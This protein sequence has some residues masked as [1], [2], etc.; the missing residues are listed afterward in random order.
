[1][2][3]GY[4][5]R[6]F[7]RPF[8]VPLP[9][10]ETLHGTQGDAV[11]HWIARAA[12]MRELCAHPRVT[13]AFARW[14]AESGIYTAARKFAD[15]R[16]DYARA[17]G[18]AGRTEMLRPDFADVVLLARV[19]KPDNIE[20]MQALLDVAEEAYEKAD[21]ATQIDPTALVR[22]L[23]R[24]GWPWVARDLAGA[25]RRGNLSYVFGDQV[26]LHVRITKRCR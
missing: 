19:E 20:R 10:V 23:V 8:G 5:G 14:G 21:A 13:E 6:P 24:A 9:Y 11:R 4:V 17:L 22:E 7:G 25:F 16:D 1:M 3:Q 2:P 12:F 26:V 18:F 15:A